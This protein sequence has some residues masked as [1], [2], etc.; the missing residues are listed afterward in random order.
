MTD[1]LIQQV[2]GLEA[3]AERLVRQ[4]QER[5]REIESQGAESVAAER[6]HVWTEARARAEFFREQAEQDHQ[7]DIR[8]VREAMQQQLT[9][10]S[11]FS[12]DNLTAQADEI[13]S[14]LVQDQ[15]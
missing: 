11:H 10:L 2:I 6:D 3:E 13:L 14:A 4:A 1:S 5:A 7:E 9:R 15:W 8:K 12:D